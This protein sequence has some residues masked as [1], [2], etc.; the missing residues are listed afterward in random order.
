MV[1]ECQ[2]AEMVMVMMKVDTYC[3]CIGLVMVIRKV[4]TCSKFM[5]W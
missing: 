4:E 3:K 1:K 5:G 2:V